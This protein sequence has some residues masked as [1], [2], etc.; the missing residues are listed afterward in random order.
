MTNHSLTKAAVKTLTSPVFVFSLT[1]LSRF[2]VLFR[3][4]PQYEWKYFYEYNE[5]ARIAWAIVSGHGFSS[6]W[7]NTPFLP[8]AQQPPLYPYVLAG[9]FK[10]AD[11]YSY[12]SLWI[13]VVLNAIF[14]AVA[15]TLILRFGTALFGILTGALAGWMWAV[16]PYEAAVSV[17]LWESS[18]SA[19]L[20]MLSLL[21]LRRI[22]ASG[23]TTEWAALGVLGGI[24]ALTNTT[25]FAVFPLFYIWLGIVRRD[26]RKVLISAGIFVLLLV[27]WTLRNYEVF[28]RWMPLRDNFGFE[29][30]MGNHEGVESHPTKFPSA[31]P[32]EYNRLGEL[33][34]M[35][36]KRENAVSFIKG[37]PAGFVWLCLR[38]LYH[39]WRD[40]AGSGWGIVSLL[41]WTGVFF[42]VWRRLVPAVPAVI[43]MIIFP[44]IYYITHTFAT[45]RHPIEPVILLFAAY[46]LASAVEPVTEWLR[47]TQVRRA[48]G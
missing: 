4:L 16:W 48:H 3:L 33:G 45:Y 19:L 34:F 37:H 41:A 18:L 38:R 35:Q 36:A 22:V 6:P 32:S 31:D 44:V 17:R 42:A 46:A 9:I 10:I 8:T 2:M 29:L 40:P 12:K 23:S 39:Y 7:P 14:S 30:W 26:T 20:L 5:P 11:A 15:G 28:H 1:L 43:V 21:L 13:A 47:N 27:P 24:A 25:F